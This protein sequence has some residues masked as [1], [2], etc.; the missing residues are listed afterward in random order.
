MQIY[1]TLTG[2]K[3]PFEPLEPGRVRM[4]N[5]GPTVYDY[6]HVGNLRTFLF[7]DVVR[8]WL[9]YR[10]YRVRYVQNFTD[11]DDKLIRRAA[12]RG[13]TVK[14]LADEQIR[15][16]FEDAD[17]LGIVRADVHP[18]VSEKIG[19]IIALIRRLIDQG[20]AYVAGGD[21]FFDVE[22]FRH[23]GKLSG[24]KTEQL[25]AGARVEAAENKRN[26]LDFA[27]WKAQKPGEP[28]WDSPWGPG[29]PG[30]H[31][32]C[33]AMAM[34]ELGQTIDIHSG[35]SDL[36]FPHHENEIAQSEAATGKPF[37]RYWMHVA[38]VQVGGQR[39][40]KSMGNF[41]R[42]RDLRAR[43]HPEAIRLFILSAH[44]RNPLEFSLEALDQAERA[45]Q[46]LANFI[47][48]LEHL[49]QVT[50]PAEAG[51]IP[52]D[53]GARG[54]GATGAAEDGGAAG[55]AGTARAAGATAATAG[56]DWPARLARARAEFEAAMDD[57][58]NTADALAALFTLARDGHKVLGPDSP[59]PWIQ[60]TLD[61]VREL[62]GPLRLFRT[63]AREEPA[64]DAQALLD[65]LV[66]VRQYA[67]SV[68]DYELADRIRHR[69]AELGYWLE[70]TPAGT[71]VRR[72]EPAA[73]RGRGA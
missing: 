43:Y 33:S 48:H 58:F 21:V 20:Y 2:Q 19:A 1:N 73:L 67:R 22:R 44:Y 63:V 57:D 55:S 70:D 60:A 66:E 27:L 4:Y 34:D 30:W 3:E 32:E 7:F 54:A 46:R 39:M 16:Y 47:A 71:R 68:R 40:G 53:L 51:G 15:A 69:L 12:E 11:I 9:E 13:I 41:W 59:R 72:G 61:L 35:G 10:G 6:F 23:Y 42:V 37:A 28:A 49:L 65:L 25:L 38:L 17:A 64:G 56:V 26:P 31:I 45:R 24:Q 14:E 50:A 36:V 62:G 18:R 29:R 52:D 5:C 8:G